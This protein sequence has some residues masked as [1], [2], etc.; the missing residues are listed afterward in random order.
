[1]AVIIAAALA[2]LFD[3]VTAEEAD[4]AAALVVSLLILLS[5]IPLI[6]GLLQSLG[7]LWAIRA[8][9]HSEAMMDEIK[10]EERKRRDK[11]WNEGKA[12]W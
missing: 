11:F 6:R 5:L 4:A 8:E 1:V 9:E 2:E 12:E 7:A 3:D 10:Q